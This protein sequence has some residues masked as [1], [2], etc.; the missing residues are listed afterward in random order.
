MKNL[1][2]ILYEVNMLEVLGNTD[3]AIQD[4]TSDSRKVQS[5][6]MFVAISGSH[7]DGHDYIDQAI[8]AGARAVLCERIP[9]SIDEDVLYIRVLRSDKAYA[10]ICENWYDNPSKTLKLVGV[11]GTN[12]K[13][14]IASMLWELHTQLGHMCGLISTNVIRIGSRV[15][16]ATHTTPDARQISSVL[17]EMANFNCSH[18]FMEVSSHGLVQRRPSALAFDGMIFT[19][20][21]HDHLDYHKSMKA[22]RDAKKLAFDGLHSSAFALVNID[23]KNGTYM[24][25]NSKA[26]IYS[27]SQYGPSDYRVRVL[28]QDIAGLVLNIDGAEVHTHMIGGFN[29]TNLLAVYAASHLLGSK[30]E[31]ILRTLSVIR[32]AKGRM[33]IVLAEESQV[34]GIIDY[35]HTPDAVQKVLEVIREVLHGGMR[36]ITVI[37]CG[38]NRDVTKRPKMGLLSARLSDMVIFTADNPRNESAQDIC[39]AM[40]DGVELSSRRKC[41]IILD[42]KEAIHKAVGL[43]QSNDIVL[44][45]GKGHE[46]T[47]VFGDKV[48]PFDDGEVLFDALKS[49]GS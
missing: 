23:D 20:L 47:Q 22:Y 35:A 29:A 13:T 3:Q 17:R 19:N 34:T 11:T 30:E 36:V 24:V 8:E 38:G 44:V 26:S 9:K 27:Y 10:R 46:T 43:A 28:E 45:A 48:M 5:D 41:S 49:M 21:T 14:S 4:F 32:G 39:Q 42:R 6:M 12:G 1:R 7:A 2:D 40:L 15:I 25:Q 31:D 16:E 18:V 37:G 33:E